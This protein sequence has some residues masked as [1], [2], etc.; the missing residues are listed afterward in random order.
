MMKTLLFGL[1][2]LLYFCVHILLNAQ[3]FGAAGSNWRFCSFVT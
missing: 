3:S 2:F 1:L